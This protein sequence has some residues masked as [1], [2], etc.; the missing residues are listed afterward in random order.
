MDENS[1]R[2]FIQRVLG[3]SLTLVSGSVIYP[4]FRFM[5]PPESSEAETSSVLVGTV[6]DLSPGSSKTFRFGTKPGL[7]IRSDSGE[8]FA[9]IAICSH[10]GCVVQHSKEKNGIWCACHDGLFD[11]HGNVVSRPPPKALTPLSVIVQNDEIYV[12]TAAT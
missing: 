3:G 9:Y 4:V 6:N 2:K 1:R 5:T 10:L 8:Y 7:R 12:T 11:L